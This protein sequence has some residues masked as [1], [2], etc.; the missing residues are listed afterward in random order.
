MTDDCPPQSPPPHRDRTRHDD[1]QFGIELV[2][3]GVGGGHRRR[4]N[5]RVRSEDEARQ[6]SERI[7]TWLRHR[8]ILA[9]KPPD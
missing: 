8:Y 9:R 4:T 3:R 6:I 1:L 7:A 5:P 2:M